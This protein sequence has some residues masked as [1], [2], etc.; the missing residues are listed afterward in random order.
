MNQHSLRLTAQ[1]QQTIQQNKPPGPSSGPSPSTPLETPV[2]RPI[3]PSLKPTRSFKSASTRGPQITTPTPNYISPRDYTTP[4][5]IPQPTTSLL[6]AGSSTVIDPDSEFPVHQIIAPY[7]A[8]LIN[9]SAIYSLRVASLRDCI[10]EAE[11]NADESPSAAGANARYIARYRTQLATDLARRDAVLSALGALTDEACELFSQKV[12]VASDPSEIAQYATT[13]PPVQVLP[14]NFDN[15]NTQTRLEVRAT[16]IR[17]RFLRQTSDNNELVTIGWPIEFR[18]PRFDYIPPPYVSDDSEDNAAQEPIVP[19]DS[20]SEPPSELDF[21]FELETPPSL[22]DS[23]KMEADEVP[24]AAAAAVPVAAE[25]D[26]IGRL[27]AAQFR[28]QLDR[29]ER[30]T[31]SDLDVSLTRWLNVMKMLFFE[32][33]EAGNFPTEA[34]GIRKI[35][36]GVLADEALDWWS[37][38]E[39]LPA[40]WLAFTELIRNE[41]GDKGVPQMK[42]GTLWSIK[43]R[44]NEK[45]S[46]YGRRLKKAN[47]DNGSAFS[48]PSDMK[49]IVMKNLNIR[50]LNGKFKVDGRLWTEALVDLDDLL[51]A[52]SDK[53]DNGIGLDIDSDLPKGGISVD[54]LEEL[55]DKS[56]KSVTSLVTKNIK[57]ETDAIKDDM[58]RVKKEVATLRNSAA[59]RAVAALHEEAQYNQYL[60]EELPYDDGQYIVAAA[61]QGN[62]RYAVQQPQPPYAAPRTYA[63]ANAGT[64]RQMARNWQQPQPLPPQQYAPPYQQPQQNPAP[65]QHNHVHWDARTQGPLTDPEAPPGSCFNCHGNHHVKDCPFKEE[66]ARFRRGLQNRD[67]NRTPG[68]TVALRAPNTGYIAANA[69]QDFGVG[70]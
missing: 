27:V 12:I 61:E 62:R 34:A 15:Y 55:L 63:P 14:N 56:N 39:E 64:N 6:T 53:Y 59:N 25:L 17:S 29:N 40:T 26:A 66:F 37:D 60:G 50:N 22:S 30:Y 35:G 68:N 21:H 57:S 58:A 65:H 23:D 20:S 46:A 32:A 33:L 10:A 28:L 9:T 11:N 43:R 5:A 1:R 16:E 8:R 2:S 7:R 51:E 69:E 45:V 38:L 49:A 4:A 48:N 31:G 52:L 67:L 47:R 36:R 13:I 19:S 70:N 41:F 18:N 24:A 3:K 54:K 44:A 42:Q